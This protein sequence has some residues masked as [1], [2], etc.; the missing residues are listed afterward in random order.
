MFI[1]NRASE[2]GNFVSDSIELNELVLS[3]CI[4]QAKWTVKP[5]KEW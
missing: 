2:W 3:F 1:K 5:H 4:F